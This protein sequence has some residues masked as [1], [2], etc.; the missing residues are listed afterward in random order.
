MKRPWLL[1]FPLLAALTFLLG[2]NPTRADAQTYDTGTI[3]LPPSM[4][5]L[6]AFD[7]SFVDP[8]S[9]TYVLADGS[10]KS[11]DVYDTKAHRLV[12]A[13]DPVFTGSPNQCIPGDIRGGNGPNGVIIVPNRGG[14][15]EDRGDRRGDRGGN[16]ARQDRGLAWAGDG[17]ST[18]KVIDLNTGHQV[19]ASI[20][21]GGHCRADELWYDPEDRMIMIGNPADTPVLQTFIST[22]G[23]PGPNSVRGQLI[24]DGVGVGTCA[25]GA[26]NGVTITKCHTVAATAGIEQPIFA[27]GHFWVAIGATSAN[28]LGEV[29]EIDPRTFQRVAAIS[30][31]CAPSG[32]TFVPPHFAATACNGGA[33]PGVRFLDLQALTIDLSPVPETAGSDQIWFNPGDGNV[34]APDSNAVG[35]CAHNYP[36]LVGPGSPPPPAAGLTAPQVNSCLAVIRTSDKT[37]IAE[38]QLPVGAGSHSVAADSHTNDVFV[39]VQDRTCSTASCPPTH[40]LSPCPGPEDGGCVHDQGLAVIQFRP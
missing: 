14:E 24:F 12:R 18:V 3:H 21:T 23:T 40:A 39:P 7:I 30:A 35:G 31:P 28:P 25:L 5:E 13:S 34:Y 32:L 4:S 9:S 1:A 16:D 36:A 17:N 37:V 11:L 27:L 15:G 29:A 10:N 26:L 33:T 8:N 22:I 2:A 6:T 20:P 19:G 38:V